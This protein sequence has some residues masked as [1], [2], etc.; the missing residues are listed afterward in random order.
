MSHQIDYEKVLI[1]LA[2][3]FGAVTVIAQLFHWLGG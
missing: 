3:F 1:R 2:L